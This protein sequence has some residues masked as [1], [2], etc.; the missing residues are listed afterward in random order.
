MTHGARVTAGEAAGA[1]PLLQRG[2]K[3]WV[4]IPSLHKEIIV[5]LEEK[6]VTVFTAITGKWKL[7]DQNETNISTHEFVPSTDV[8]YMNCTK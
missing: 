6:L 8:Q 1:G 2:C 5:S 3:L 4:K 7:R